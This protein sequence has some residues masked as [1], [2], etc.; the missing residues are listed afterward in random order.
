MGA[1][2]LQ[3]IRDQMAGGL[4]DFHLASIFGKC[5]TAKTD[6]FHFQSAPRVHTKNPQHC[7]PKREAPDQMP[8]S[9]H[10]PTF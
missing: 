8:I 10:L 9:R 7:G 6:D 4:A 5:Q 1:I 3:S 2:N